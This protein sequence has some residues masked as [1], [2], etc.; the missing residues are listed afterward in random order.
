MRYT[1]KTLK[2]TRNSDDRAIVINASDFDEEL[3]T[4]ADGEELPPVN[5]EPEKDPEWV[6]MAIQNGEAVYWTG[7]DWN[8]E[9]TGAKIYR[10]DQ[11]ARTAIKNT[12]AIQAGL[13][14][15]EITE[16]E[17]VAL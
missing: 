8:L 13:S 6:I 10:D 9:E 15:G 12:K 3:Y 16:P 14:S 4:L 11:Y 1:L 7:D 5:D 17:E 2:C